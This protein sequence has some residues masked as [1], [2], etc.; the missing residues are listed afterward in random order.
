MCQLPSQSHIVRGPEP[1][2]HRPPA[3]YVDSAVI[4][5]NHELLVPLITEKLNFC[6]STQV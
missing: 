5:M 2:P 4:P 1:L 6:P 3:Q